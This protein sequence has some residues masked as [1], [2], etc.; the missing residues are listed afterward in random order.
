[1][2]ASAEGFRVVAFGGGTG[3]AALLAGLRRYTQDISAVVTVTDNGGSSGILRNDYDMVAPGDIR[4]CLIALADVDPLFLE[5]LRYR[6]EDGDFKGHCFGNLFI[7][8]LTRIVGSFEES[9]RVMNRLLGVRGKV[10]PAAGGRIS[11]VARHPDGTK[12]TGEVQISKSGKPI[13]RVELRPG[14]VPISDEI[15]AAVREADLFVIGPGSLFTSIIPNLILVGLVEEIQRNGS[16]TVYVS[17]MM[18][19]PG[20]TDGFRLSDHIRAI[21]RHAGDAVPD[22]V[23]A[24]AASLPEAVVA[25]YGAGRAVPVEIDIEGVPEFRGIRLIRGDFYGG[26]DVARHDPELLART[27]CREFFPS[28]ILRSERG[29]RGAEP[30]RRGA[31]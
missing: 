4:N 12:S 29:G 30:A 1:M 26:G 7:T 16:P 8:V 25:R 28:G 18:T 3:M 24:Q 5:S 15:R 9:I 13:E 2:T 22:W 20:E 14:P 11:L 31:P 17:N 23:I 6:F 27:I 10:I 19:Q 21:R